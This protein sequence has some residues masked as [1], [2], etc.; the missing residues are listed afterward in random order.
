MA[1]VAGPLEDRVDVGGRHDFGL[2]R[3][4]RP[5]NR[6]GLNQ[7]EEEKKSEPSTAAC[8]HTRRTSQNARPV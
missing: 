5:I 3:R 2:D 4:I 7:Q 1:V 8:G 6:H